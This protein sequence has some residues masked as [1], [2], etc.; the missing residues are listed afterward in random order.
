MKIIAYGVR[1]DEMPFLKEWQSNNPAIEVQI[2][3]E[4]LD[5]KSVVKAKGFDAV[6]AFQQNPYTAE[7]LNQL[8]SFGVK[9]LSLR[10]VGVD[11]VDFA[12]AKQNNIK[13]T[14]VPAYSPQAIAEFTVTQLLQ[15][16]RNT[17]VFNRKI[18]SGDLRWAPDISTEFNQLTVGVFATGRIGRAALQ[19]YKGFGA[20]VIAYDIYRNPELEKEGIY[21]DTPEDLYRQADV[22]S[23]HA[24][25]VKENEH[26]LNDETFAEMKDGV[27]I[28]NPARGTLIDTDALIRALDSGKVGGAALDVYEGEVGVF[29]EKFDSFDA[30]PDERV[31]DLLKRDNVLVTPHVAFYTKSAVNSMVNTSLDA[32]RDVVETGDSDKIVPNN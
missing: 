10:N 31:K 30:I 13:I 20:K 28:L 25:A 11:T 14:N 23:L 27:I 2:E 9:V 12:A 18:A 17:K 32:G 16:L 24:P 22:I 3:R 7:V 26:M 15:L 8:G 19:I 5:E 6:N 1:D 21:V 29:N 4:L